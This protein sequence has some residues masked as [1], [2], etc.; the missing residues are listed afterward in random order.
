MNGVAVQDGT[1]ISVITIIPKRAKQPPRTA[2]DL[3]A[4]PINAL[5]TTKTE[6]G[7][8]RTRTF[9]GTRY[10]PTLPGTAASARGADAIGMG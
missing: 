7:R 6:A 1:F 9:V 4:G 10:G 5:S 2:L 3:S 8:S